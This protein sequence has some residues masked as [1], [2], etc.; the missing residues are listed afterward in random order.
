MSGT[1]IGIRIRR[2]AKMTKAIPMIRF[3][4][5]PGV[6]APHRE[7][8]CPTR[9]RRSWT[10]SRRIITLR[11][12]SSS[13]SGSSHP[14]MSVVL[15]KSDSPPLAWCCLSSC[16]NP[17]CHSTKKVPQLLNHRQRWKIWIVIGNS[18]IAI[19]SEKL[20]SI[21]TI[22]LSLHYDD[23][24]HY[25]QFAIDRKVARTFPSLD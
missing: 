17:L 3:E 25:R 18:T 20:F 10:K 19:G 6:T 11:S 2:K 21:F 1:L 13:P 4:L 14:V 8:F 5:W 24:P 9:S 12:S 7:A 15:W 23:H 16:P 22:N